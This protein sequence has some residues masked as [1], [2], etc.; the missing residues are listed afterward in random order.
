MLLQRDRAVFEARHMVVAMLR[1]TQ[2]LTITVLEKHS[3][4]E[5]LGATPTPPSALRAGVEQGWDPRLG[6][7]PGCFH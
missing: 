5:G 3:V 2:S 1:G 4:V 6:G 7:D